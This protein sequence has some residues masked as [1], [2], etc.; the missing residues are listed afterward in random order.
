L[1]F[2]SKKY[3]IFLTTQKVKEFTW[4]DGTEYVLPVKLTGKLVKVEN[5]RK[6]SNPGTILMMYQDPKSPKHF[7]V[8]RGGRTYEADEIEVLILKDYGKEKDTKAAST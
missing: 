6:K 5:C 4:I 3:A 8:L 7:V 1:R 2:F